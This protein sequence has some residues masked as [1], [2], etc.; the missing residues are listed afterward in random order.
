[1]LFAW[2]RPGWDFA[3]QATDAQPGNIVEARPFAGKDT[4]KD[5]VEA[6]FARA[7]GASGRADDRC[8]ADT[9]KNKQIAGIDGHADMVYDAACVT[10]G[11]G[12]HIVRIGDRRRSED[13]QQ[14]M[15]R[16]QLIDCRS[17]RA[18]RVRNPSL[19]QKLTSRLSEPRCQDGFRLVHHLRLQCWQL[20]CY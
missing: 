19:R 12:N 2:L 11:C 17:D 18:F 15:I 16:L 7:A 10:D 9:A 4:I 13:H 8:R 20:S 3:Q 5:P 1:M 6:I 14:I